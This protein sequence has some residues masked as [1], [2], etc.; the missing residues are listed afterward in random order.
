M[1]TETETILF[2]TVFDK[3]RYHLHK[4]KIFYDMAKS[5]NREIPLTIFPRAARE[6]ISINEWVKNV[7]DANSQQTVVSTV[8][9]SYEGVK[10]Y[11][12]YEANKFL[13]NYLECKITTLSYT[14]VKD[15]DFGNLAFD[16]VFEIDGEKIAIEIKVTQSKDQFMGST[17]SPKK[18]DDYIFIA[19]K[20]DRDTPVEIGNNYLIGMMVAMKSFSANAWKGEPKDN[21]SY[22]SLKMDNNQ[23]LICGGLNPDGSFKYEEIIYE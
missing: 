16:V 5:V 9:L 8:R 13:E 11:F 14:E 23:N 15:C 3:L 20:V 22:T 18:V 10:S 6:N 7:E 17:H 1:T 19:L 21:S 4:S 2:T 12:T